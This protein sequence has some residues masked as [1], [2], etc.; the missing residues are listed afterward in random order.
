MKL[1]GLVVP[2]V[3]PFVDGRIDA[4]ALADHC[5][6]VVGQGA[7]GV[8]LFGTTGEGPSISVAEKLATARALL[9]RFPGVPVI[10]SVTETSLGAALECIRGYN[11]LG[12]AAVLVLPPF[13]FRE[14]PDDGIVAFMRAVATASEHPVLG[15][16]IPSMAP[17]LPTAMWETLWGVKDSGADPGYARTASA[18][19]KVVFVGAESLIADAV[20][21][22]ARGAIAGMGNVAPAAMAELCR[23][24]AAGDSDGARR[25]AGKVLALQREI[26]STAP[27][28]E[29]VAAF[30]DIA[31]TLHGT[32]L[33]DPLPPLARRRT[34]LTPAVLAALDACK[35]RP[36]PA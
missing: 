24:A 6:W 31:G 23:S 12:L 9:S 14:E 7:T 13:Y 28:L 15:Y 17:A 19:G 5:E 27:G 26:L 36:A 4:A 11:E 32:N 25:A 22:G 29:F 33:G 16:H 3:T 10:G 2:V 8:M 30:K 18:A 35:T 1:A 34:Y 20:A 21:V